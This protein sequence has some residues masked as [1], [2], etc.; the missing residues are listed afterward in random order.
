M[1]VRL[2][3]IFGRCSRDMFGTGHRRLR[4][5]S[6]LA[7]LRPFNFMHNSGSTWS[8]LS[9]KSVVVGLLA[10]FRAFSSNLTKVL[11]AS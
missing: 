11:L 6:P 8:D 5:Q 1:P 10:N 9:P 2:V 4:Q 7:D 3:E